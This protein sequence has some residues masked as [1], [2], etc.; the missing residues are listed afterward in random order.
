MN[1]FNKLFLSIYFVPGT[2][3]DAWDASVN[4][5]DQGAGSRIM[6]MQ[7]SEGDAVSQV[8]IW[9]NVFQAKGQ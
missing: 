5:P 8:D 2:I 4:K 7:N 1:I 6:T 3:L 9:E